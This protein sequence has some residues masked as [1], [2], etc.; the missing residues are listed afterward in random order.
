MNIRGQWDVV[1]V[2]CKYCKK[3]FHG[4]LFSKACKEC[5]YKNW[6]ER[7]RNN[8]NRNASTKKR[9][10]RNREFVRS[11]KKDKKCEICGYNKYPEILD[12]HHKDDKGKVATI[13]KL[14]KNLSNLDTI[15]SE[16]NKCMLVCP[17]CHREL[18]VKAGM[19]GS[20]GT[21]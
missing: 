17:N 2:D 1:V 9:M 21:R 14:M 6:K 8:P 16:I 7:Q 4:N 12:F 10:L 11:Y 13:N 19:W 18:H 5:Q 20:N 3:P 15:Q